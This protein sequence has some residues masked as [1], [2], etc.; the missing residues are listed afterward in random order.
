MTASVTNFTQIWSGITQ[1]AITH[2]P[3]GD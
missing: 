3:T 1:T 2:W